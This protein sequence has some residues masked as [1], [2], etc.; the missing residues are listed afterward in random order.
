MI[1]GLELATTQTPV[2]TVICIA[3][4]NLSYLQP[5]TEFRGMNCTYG[6]PLP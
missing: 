5:M 2:Y 4:D 3:M 6:M 1:R